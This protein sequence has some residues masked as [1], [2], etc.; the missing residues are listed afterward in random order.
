MKY[1]NDAIIGN[2]NMIATYS[3]K[4]ELL[5]ILYPNVDQI[6]LLDF[7]STGVKINDSNLILLHDDINNTYHQY[8]TNHTNILNTEITNSY[9]NLKIDRKDFVTLK[10]NR[11]IQKYVFK[12][13]GTIDLEVDLLI[14]SQMH[15]Q[16]NC[17]TRRMVQR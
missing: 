16:N 12:N 2:K 10:E 15:T 14:H 6:Q 17:K 13:E 7:F 11:I 1:Y 4:G 3:K 8:Y 9:F 5:R